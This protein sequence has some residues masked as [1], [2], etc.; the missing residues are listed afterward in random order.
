MAAVTYAPALLFACHVWWGDSWVETGWLALMIALCSF[1]TLICTAMIYAS[2]KTIPAWHHPLV[3]PVYVLFAF[4]TGSLCF[5][6]CAG[7]PPLDSL[8]GAAVTAVVLS[9]IKWSYWRDIDRI[10]LP[11]REAATAL[12]GFGTVASFERPH[13][14]ANYLTR[15]MGFV[16]ARKHSRKLRT[17]ALI[18]FAGIPLLALLVAWL[19]PTAAPYALWIA[20]LSALLGAFVERWLFFAEAKHVVTL[21]Y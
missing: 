13:T 3:F 2:L 19:V 11:S 21:Y 15:E 20:A 12:E 7:L 18:L 16:L 4:L 17:I 9:L 1:M 5:G 10:E 14:E 8:I 6:C